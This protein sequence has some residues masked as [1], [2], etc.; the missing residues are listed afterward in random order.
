MNKI[1]NILDGAGTVAIAGHVNPD[2]DCIGS[3]MAMYLYLKE[4]YKQLDVD[5]YLGEL[6]PVFGYIERIQEVKHQADAGKEYDL[7]L[8][9]DVSSA[10]RI[11][12]AGEYLSTAKRSVCIDHHITNQGLADENYILPD[13]SSTCEVLYEMLNPDCISFA[14]ATALYT[15][16]VHDTG[17]FQY[18]NTK[19]KTMRIAGEL[20][21]KGVDNT[22]IIEDSFYSKTYVQNQILGRTLMESLL[23]LDGK[24]IIG[25]VRQKEMDFY[26][27]TPKDL[28]G[29]VNQ[30]RVTQG[31]EVA[32]FI[33]AIGNQ[34]YKVSM[35]SNG[36]IDVSEIA[37]YF[38]GGGHAKAAGCN[39]Q[40]SVYDAINSITFYIEKKLLMEKPL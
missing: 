3:C 13:A 32:I 22:A 8:L 20:L 25:I 26:N 40:G 14:A 39:M 9:F 12:V 4:N 28:D 7:L 10:D 35:R 19:G 17:V 37:G 1:D 34:E 24:C 31:V 18:S 16:I 11:A 2:G 6:R 29:I 36:H 23:I 33:Y 38:G 15:G 27:V 5:V 21:D 30:L